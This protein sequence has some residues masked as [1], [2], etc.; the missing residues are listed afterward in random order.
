[1]VRQ[2]LVSHELLT[3]KASRAHWVRH[4]LFGRIPLEEW[5]ARRRDLY[6]AT[7]NTHKRQITMPPAGL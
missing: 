6:L 1:M 7:H 2:P 4:N 5:L 3:A